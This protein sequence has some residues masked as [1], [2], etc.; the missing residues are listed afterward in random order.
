MKNACRG[1]GFDVRI[2]RPFLVPGEETECSWCH[3][4]V[5]VTRS[6]RLR[7]HSIA[8]APVTERVIGRPRVVEATAEKY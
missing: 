8:D 2:S 6:L 7:A 5:T 1:S 3:R 4:T